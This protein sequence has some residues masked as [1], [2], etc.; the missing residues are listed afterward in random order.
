LVAHHDADLQGS[1][2]RNRQTRESESGK[3]MS[4]RQMFIIARYWAALNWLVAEVRYEHNILSYRRF[5]GWRTIDRRE[6]IASGVVWPPFIAYVRLNR[7]VPPWGRL[8]F[9][10]DTNE[11]PNPFRRGIHPILR[12]L[13]ADARK[14]NRR[15]S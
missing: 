15:M 3:L 10:P 2:L 6:V 5:G 1:A 7:F 12:H 11:E 4:D 13:Q 14:G 9:V 8:Y